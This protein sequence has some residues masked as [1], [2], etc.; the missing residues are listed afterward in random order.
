MPL[1]VGNLLIDPEANSFISLADAD[2][3][4]EAEG[5]GAW[6]AA[7]TEA[8]EAA[9][10]NASRWMAVSLNWCHKDLSDEELIVVGRA[11]A[12]LA[13]QALTVDLWA[14]ENVG[15]DAKRYKAGSVEVEYQNRRPVAGPVAAGKRFPWL[16]PML[17]SLISS[18]TSRWLLRV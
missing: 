16:L 12:R 11:A 2:A 13:V 6:Q 17:G 8:K 18:G 3:Y 5:A 10:V 4:L 14:P 15:K 9:L 1:V 7:P